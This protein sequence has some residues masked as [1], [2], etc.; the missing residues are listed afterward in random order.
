VGVVEVRGAEVRLRRLWA[1]A[2]LL[3]VTGG[4][5]YLVWYYRVNRELRD[6]GRAFGPPNPLDVDLLRTVLAVTLG[7]FVIVPA[8]ISVART[9]ERILRAERLSGT[10][11]TLSSRAGLVVFVAAL[12]LF[13]IAVAPVGQLLQLTVSGVALALLAGKLAYTQHH[14]NEIWRRE[15]ARAA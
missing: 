12:V 11:R 15:L 1:V 9:F 3:V 7:G 13:L 10:A 6:Y 2:A 8:A 5:Y 4:F 14:V